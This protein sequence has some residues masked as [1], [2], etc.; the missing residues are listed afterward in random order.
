MSE[1]SRALQLGECFFRSPRR[2]HL[3]R[4]ALAAALLLAALSPAAARADVGELVQGDWSFSLNQDRDSGKRGLSVD[5]N[6]AVAFF[7]VGLTLRSWDGSITGWN[8]HQVSNEAV[9]YYGVGVLNLIVVQR[10]HSSAGDRHRIHLVIPVSKYYTDYVEH[11]SGSM[12]I[13]GLLDHVMAVTPFMEYGGGKKVYGVG[14]EIL[15]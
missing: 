12:K 14:V 3:A 2:L 8:G 1:T 5:W 9:F 13:N 10:G 15:F 6:V 7:N 4:G 11:N